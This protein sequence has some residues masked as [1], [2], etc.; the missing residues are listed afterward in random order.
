MTIIAGCRLAENKH[1]WI[2]LTRIYGIG[3]TRA[4]LI[5][6]TAKVN[7][8]TKVKDL[9]DSVEKIRTVITE[10]G[11]SI[12]PALKRV[13]RKAISIKKVI[14]CYQGRRLTVGLPVNGQRTKTNAK[15]SRK[16]RED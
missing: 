12:G 10:S 14:R 6:K 16:R 1:I 3:K 8:E 5:C 13:R 11:W 15:T 9:G 7:P 4:N 2:G